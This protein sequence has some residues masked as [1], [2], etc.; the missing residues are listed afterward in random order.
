MPHP[1]PCHPACSMTLTSAVSITRR[2]NDKACCRHQGWRRI[3]AI[4][5]SPLPSVWRKWH[6]QSP[7]S[8]PV[9]TF[10]FPV[11]DENG[12]VQP[13]FQM[14][15]KDTG[16]QQFGCLSKYLSP[17]SV[18]LRNESF[19]FEICVHFSLNCSNLLSPLPGAVLPFNLSASFA[20]LLLF[21]AVFPAASL[22]TVYNSAHSVTFI[23]RPGVFSHWL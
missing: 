20:L 1:N 22:A 3:K 2:A 13:L 16:R 14:G 19:V 10:F 5:P 15:G 18:S 11:A 6:F 12:E 8:W 17:L 9:V 23:F 21:H 4:S 7:F